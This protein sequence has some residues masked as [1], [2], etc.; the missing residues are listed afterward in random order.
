MVKDIILLFVGAVVGAIVGIPLNE[1]WNS[2][3]LRKQKKKEKEKNDEINKEL[4]KSEPPIQGTKLPTN[5]RGLILMVS[6]SPT[7]EEACRKAI[8]YHENNL[9][10]LW[11]IASTS[12]LNQTEGSLPLAKKLQATIIA[13]LGIPVDI[14][15]LSEIDIFDPLEVKH[16]IER[17]FDT[18][19]INWQ[20][21]DVIGDYTG[22]PAPASIGMA[23]G[24]LNRGARLQ[25]VPAKR[26]TEDSV[27]GSGTPIATILTREMLLEKVASPPLPISTPLETLTRLDKQ[28]IQEEATKHV[29]TKIT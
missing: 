17:I 11:L 20:P 24:C 8:A 22:M 3:K 10:K 12:G 27:L 14:I 21:S 13:N 2:Y 6:T 29:N 28:K 7:A 5:C 4:S 19:P 26:S 9:D 25:Y 15:P 16:K 18:L 1:I 23:F